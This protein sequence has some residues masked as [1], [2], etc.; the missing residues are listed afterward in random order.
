MRLVEV[1]IIRLRLLVARRLLFPIS[2]VA[3]RFGVNLD[4]RAK[5]ILAE[6]EAWLAANQVR[7]LTKRLP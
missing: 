7:P 3:C 5:R 1:I 6:S 4:D 2:H